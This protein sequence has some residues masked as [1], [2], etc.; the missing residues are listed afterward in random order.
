V[1]VDENA[2]LTVAPDVRHDLRHSA[3]TILML[4][5]MLRSD[6]HDT[7]THAAFDGIAHCARS[8]TD[9]VNKLDERSAQQTVDVAKLASQLG[10]HAGL[11]YPGTLKVQAEPAPVHAHE[12]DISRLL[13]NLIQNACRAAGADG[14]VHLTVENEDSWCVIRVGDSG[15]GF[16]EKPTYAGLGL[17]LVASVAVR[18]E[19]YITLG[20]SPL[21]GAL[22]AVHLPRSQL[23]EPGD[24]TDDLGGEFGS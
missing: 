8:I 19:G 21:G 11:L 13:T 17:A 7:A 2:D 22:V 3:S 20:R 18:L 1:T 10:D 16:V 5:A 14:T 6:D 12:L 15:A 23:R 24:E 9:M 4:V